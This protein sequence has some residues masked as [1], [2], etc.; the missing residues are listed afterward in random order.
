M[1]RKEAQARLKINHLLEEAGWRLFDSEQGKHNVTVE[2][3]VKLSE[4]GDDFEH[5]PNGFIDYLLHDSHGFPLAVLEAKRESVHPLT[6]RNKP[7][8]TLTPSMPVILFSPTV[9]PITFGILKKE[10]PS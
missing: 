3:T 2:D 10:I 5:A 4:L 7:V 8:P 1:S 9:T 6:G